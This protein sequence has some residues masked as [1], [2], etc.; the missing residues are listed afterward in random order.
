MREIA[1]KLGMSESQIAEAYKVVTVDDSTYHAWMAEVL[2]LKPN[3]RKGWK[4]TLWNQRGERTR[5]RYNEA[6]GHFENHSTAHA[7]SM[8]KKY[9]PWARVSPNSSAF[10]TGEVIPTTRVG[11]A[12]MVSDGI[13]ERTFQEELQNNHTGHHQPRNHFVQV[14]TAPGEPCRG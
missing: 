12:C 4:G 6:S 14:P 13:G 3:K 1:E 2:A 11:A 8:L 10:R 7:N 5:V 9:T